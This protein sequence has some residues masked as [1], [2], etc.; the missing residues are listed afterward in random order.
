MLQAGGRDERV[1]HRSY[2]RQGVDREPGEHYGPAGAHM[3][4][5]GVDHE[6]L[7]RAAGTLDVQDAV[8]SID[9]DIE[10]LE[11]AS[12]VAPDAEQDDR[13]PD[14]TTPATPGRDEDLS[15]GR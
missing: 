2:E 6:R 4:G 7:R 10:V 1:D 9:R 5:R 14:S 13:R 8:R 11:R 12:E 15:P 3:T